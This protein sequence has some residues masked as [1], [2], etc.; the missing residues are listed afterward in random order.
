MQWGTVSRAP[1]ARPLLPDSLRAAGAALVAAC[2]AVVL[3]AFVAGRGNHLTAL[4]GP[5]AASKPASSQAST[6]LT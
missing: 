4:T 5:L 2:V 6:G 3:V 1:E